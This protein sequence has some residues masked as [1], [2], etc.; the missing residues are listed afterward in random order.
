MPLSSEQKKVV[1]SIFKN[2]DKVI[3]EECHIYFLTKCKESKLIPLNFKLK[4]TLPGN[5][6]LN[7]EKLDQ[8]SQES[9][10]DEKQRHVNILNQQKLHLKKINLV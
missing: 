3:N 4:N 5:K 9:I 1:K 7:Q 2:G 8:I 6:H 10:I